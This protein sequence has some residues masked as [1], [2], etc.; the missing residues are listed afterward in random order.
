MVPQVAGGDG[1]P[2]AVDHGG[3]GGASTGERRAPL[4]LLVPVFLVDDAVAHAV[5]VQQ[6]RA[7]QDPGVQLP[8]EATDQ[9]I[10]EELIERSAAAVRLLA[11]DLDCEQELPIE[12]GQRHELDLL[13]E[14]GL[15][16][17]VTDLPLEAGLLCGADMP[18][19]HVVEPSQSRR[20]TCEAV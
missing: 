3:G 8:T 11:Q 19:D 20:V 9:A 16:R 12:S 15:R 13:L 6:A 17:G 2:V 7:A 1:A 18:C 4:P 14:S 5:E 10:Y